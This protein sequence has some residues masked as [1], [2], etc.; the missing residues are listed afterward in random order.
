MVARRFT[1]SSPPRCGRLP[2]LQNRTYKIFRAL[3]FY[4]SPVSKL[5]STGI[6]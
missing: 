5:S 4:V 2:S 6:E 1:N 3:R